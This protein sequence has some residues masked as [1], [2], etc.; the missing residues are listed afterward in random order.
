MLPFED[1]VH[2]TPHPPDDV[3]IAWRGRGNMS[4]DVLKEEF[5]PTVQKTSISLVLFVGNDHEIGGPL[6]HSH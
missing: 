4:Q 2:R 6:G 3:Q 5:S 1:L